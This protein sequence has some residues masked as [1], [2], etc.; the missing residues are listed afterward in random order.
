M[1]IIIKIDSDDNK[2]IN[3]YVD[4]N[5]RIIRY[6]VKKA[7]HR[8]ISFVTDCVECKTSFNEIQIHLINICSDLFADPT[9][10][11]FPPTRFQKPGIDDLLDTQIVDGKFND[12]F[13]LVKRLILDALLNN[14]ANVYDKYENLVDPYDS[15]ISFGREN[16]EK[17]QFAINY[18]YIK[19][20]K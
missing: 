11:L 10:E 16:L 13:D 5:K 19:V 7:G 15:E 4:I 6:L 17:Y 2:Y 9:N 3:Y 20:K 12:T 14:H 8:H 18:T 1:T